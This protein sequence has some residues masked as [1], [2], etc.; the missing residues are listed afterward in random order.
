MMSVVRFWFLYSYSSPLP[1]HAAC[2]AATSRDQDQE[3]IRKDW[4]SFCTL[5][6]GLRD[7]FEN[8]YFL[9]FWL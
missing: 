6:N 5:K 4:S 1:P 3:R 8:F 7:V 9:L 2:D